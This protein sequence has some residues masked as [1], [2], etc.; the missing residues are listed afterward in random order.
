MSTTKIAILGSTGSIG[1]QTLDVIAAFPESFEV[2]ALTAHSNVLEL[3]C[4]AQRWHPQWLG[5]VD[6]T[7]VDNF[8]P[9]MKEQQILTG[10]TCL[11][12]IAQLPEVDM[13]VVAVAGTAGLVATIKAIMAGK[14]VALANKETLVSGGSLVIEMARAKG[15]NIY[16]IDSEHSALWQCLTGEQMESVDKL[17]LTASGGPFVRYDL[18]QL[19][20]VVPKQALKHPTWNMGPKISIDSATLMN[21]GLEVIEASVL[22]GLAG[23]DIDVVVHPQSIVH[24]LVSFTDGAVKAQLGL[25][26]MRQPIQYALFGGRRKTNNLK[27]L[28]L[29]SVGELTFEAPDTTKFPCLAL[30]YA[31]LKQGG[32]L[33]AVLNTVNEIAVG[34][35]LKHQ[36]GF[37][38]IPR[39]IEKALSQHEVIYSPKLADII[40][41]QE[42]AVAYIKQHHH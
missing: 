32:T 10:A 35:F 39:L 27:A 11:E 12:E 41:A 28:D 29:V 37:M 19:T 13:V 23:K 21:K 15:V 17:I 42:W 18:S 25:P 38:D 30:A 4:Q 40:N 31:A 14:N 2:V 5:L 24:S 9:N 6:S 7:A 8:N 26:D 1:R 34:L 33:P 16:P 20:D 22:F 3:A 36:I